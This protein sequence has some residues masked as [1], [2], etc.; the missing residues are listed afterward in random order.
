MVLTVSPVYF[1]F[2]GQVRPPRTPRVALSRT[3][4]AARRSSTGRTPHVSLRCLRPNILLRAS[5]ARQSRTPSRRPSAAA[6]PSTSRRAA[7]PR[8]CAR[9]AK[10]GHHL[11]K[12]KA[13]HRVAAGHHHHQ[14]PVY[15]ISL[16]LA[17]TPISAQHAW[18]PCHAGAR[19]VPRAVR[20]V[21]AVALL[22]RLRPDRD[23][24]HLPH[25][26]GLRLAAAQ[27]VADLAAR[28]VLPRR[29][30]AL[31]PAG[32]DTPP[33]SY[34][35]ILP[36]S[37]EAPTHHRSF[38]PL[39]RLSFSPPHCSSSTPVAPLYKPTGL[40]APHPSRRLCAVAG[41]DGGRRLGAVVAR[42]ARAQGGGR[43]R[44]GA[45]R[46]RVVVAVLPRRAGTPLRC[47]CR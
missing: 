36:T 35:P 21:R 32:D 28:R 45:R 40:R 1:I 46:A 20:R 14:R 8:S 7:T 11:G 12:G 42:L 6:A 38:P 34:P 15:A 43:L 22:R 13:G 16:R 47:A 39:P 3:P 27:H 4:H 5:V 29:T 9:K 44:R 41:V 33:P 10:S 25:L 31:Q 26:V 23:A 2:L 18:P 24:R 37:S 30:V 17:T 19:A